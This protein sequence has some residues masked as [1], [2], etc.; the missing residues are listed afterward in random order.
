M[1]LAD[2]CGLSSSSFK[3]GTFHQNNRSVDE[4]LFRDV[5]IASQQFSMPYNF[6]V[7]DNFSFCSVVKNCNSL[8][9]RLHSGRGK[10]HVSRDASPNNLR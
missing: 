4:A 8:Q 1:A 6:D 7:C 9:C 3:T 2:V 10:T 5:D